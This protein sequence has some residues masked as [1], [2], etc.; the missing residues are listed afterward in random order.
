MSAAKQR[1]KAEEAAK[2]AEADPTAAARAKPTKSQLA[3][4]RAPEVI[5]GKSTSNLVA[6]DYG[7]D[8]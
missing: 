5:T 3:H 2:A 7:G 1:Q 6:C 4:T 8:L